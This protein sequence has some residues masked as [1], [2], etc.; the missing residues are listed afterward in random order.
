MPAKKKLQ[1]VF[2]NNDEFEKFIKATIIDAMSRDPR[3]DKEVSGKVFFLILS[4]V[5]FIMGEYGRRFANKEMGDILNELKTDEE[6]K[7]Y[8]ENCLKFI[9]SV[10]GEERGGDAED[11]TEQEVSD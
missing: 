6:F 2:K 11:S 5:K 1:T 7:E 3:D 10:T 4:R 9:E 8:R